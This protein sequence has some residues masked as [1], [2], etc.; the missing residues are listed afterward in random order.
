MPLYPCRTLLLLCLA[1]LMLGGPS[2]G[3]AQERSQSLYEKRLSIIRGTS[4]GIVIYG[5]EKSAVPA[6]APV[7]V[8]APVAAASAPKALK[9]ESRAAAEVVPQGTAKPEILSTL[10]RLSGRSMNT[11]RSLGTGEPGI[12][13]PTTRSASQ[14]TADPVAK[15]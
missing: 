4:P 12:Q 2:I 7:P 3:F 9:A 6:P 10:P 5:G 1:T 14:S 8:P 13:I 11:A 15:P